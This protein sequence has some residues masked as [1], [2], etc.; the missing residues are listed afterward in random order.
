MVTHNRVNGLAK[1]ICVK[2]MIAGHLEQKGG[3]RFQHI[4]CG[5]CGFEYPSDLEPEE[6]QDASFIA[7]LGAQ[8]SGKST[9]LASLVHKLIHDRHLTNLFADIFD[10][11]I[12]EDKGKYYDRIPNVTELINHILYEN[13]YPQAT[14]NLVA[15][16]DNSERLNSG[17]G[18][19][20]NKKSSKNISNNSNN[21]VVVLSN[22]ENK[23]KVVLNF[24]DIAG[25]NLADPLKLLSPAHEEILRIFADADAAI[26]I[27]DPLN[28]SQIFSM[29][30][31]YIDDEERQRILT[32]Q[33]KRDPVRIINN[34]RE[35]V[36]R[37][38]RAKSSSQPNSLGEKIFSIFGGTL[39]ARKHNKPFA[40][41]I[42]KFDI[43]SKHNPESINSR[44]KIHASRGFRDVD[45]IK[46]IND[47]YMTVA[48]I[49]AEHNTTK[50]G[51][52]NIIKT[53]ILPISRSISEKL[54]EFFQKINERKFYFTIEEN[55]STYCF[56]PV[57]SFIPRPN[58]PD[59]KNDFIDKNAPMY[60]QGV[61]EPLIWIMDK[62]KF[63]H[64]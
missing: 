52:L 21:T 25:E 6:C 32:G 2:C 50:A 49:R 12:F 48:A 54:E 47:R 19:E 1:Y 40:I 20:E 57:V 53:R 37:R 17:Q 16:E 64:R 59:Q 45:I 18:L 3:E 42:N 41:C 44:L 38:E 34:F 46:S 8:N 31:N 63:F 11:R 27:V 61:I 36:L 30:E 9:F 15:D 62:I 26:L 5:N 7:I 43:I 4:A 22:K 24:L 14:T 56:F 35:I 55:F 28:L 60:S 23:K 33:E 10:C 58:E 51:S 13:K 39:K 29:L